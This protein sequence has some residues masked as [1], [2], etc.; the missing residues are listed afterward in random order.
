MFELTHVSEFLI[1]TSNFLVA[2]TAIW[3]SKIT[4]KVI[5]EEH[6]HTEKME[7]IEKHLIPNEE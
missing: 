7:I 2:G 3:L 5:E 4:Y 1:I 6:V